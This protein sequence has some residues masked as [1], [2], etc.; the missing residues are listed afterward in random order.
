MSD[1]NGP[2]RLESSTPFLVLAHKSEKPP[3]AEQF[4]SRPKLEL[5]RNIGPAYAFRDKPSPLSSGW[6]ALSVFSGSGGFDLGF[7][8]EGVFSQQAIDI[9]QVACET[10]SRNLSEVARVADLASFVPLAGTSDVLLAG[11]PCQ[12]FSTA[13]KRLLDDPRNALLMRVADIAIANR[14][15]VLVV[16]NVP[17]AL[18][19]QHRHLWVALEDR[20]R[21]AGYNVRRILL[22]GNKCGLAQRRKRLFLV[23]W[24][25]SDCINL[26]VKNGGSISLRHALGGLAPA[27]ENEL[28]W[29]DPNGK[30]AKILKH[31]KP[32]QKLSNVRLSD[33][34]VS[35]WD[36]PK[37]FGFVSDAEKDILVA[38][39]RLRRR[40]RVRSYGDGDP[41]SIDRIAHFLNRG[42]TRNVRRL[43]RQGFLR[44]VD[45]KFE[46]TQTYNGRYRRL[47]WEDVSPTVDTRFGRVDLFVHPEQDR[48]FTAREAAR[49]Q[50]FPDDFVFHGKP[51]EIFTQIGNAVP[52]PMAAA[53]AAFVREAILKA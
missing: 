10:Y 47:S 21:A 32:G 9:D 14:T 29:P 30:D 34:S 41:V 48:G 1:T 46:L 24:K 17:A 26:G 43:V 16:E 31:I 3:T 53:L 27:S 42:V 8:Q 4:V 22:E 15:K 51:K 39:A 28:D 36:I 37:V 6:R 20:L 40:D 38:V 5:V 11:A 33:S 50:G 25:G 7:L 45:G 35:T 19:G 52:P 12:G 18:S 13:G 49:I 44:E 23:C 2:N